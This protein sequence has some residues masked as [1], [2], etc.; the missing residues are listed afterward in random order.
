MGANVN[1]EVHLDAAALW[2]ASLLTLSPPAL[3]PL[4]SASK[5]AR[6]TGMTPSTTTSVPAAD[7]AKAAAAPPMPPRLTCWT[8][9]SK[10]HVEPYVNNVA[11]SRGYA[12]RLQC[13]Q[14]AGKPGSAG[15]PGLAGHMPAGCLQSSPRR[16]PPRQ[17]SMRSMRH[18]D[19]QGG[20]R[21]ARYH[22]R[23]DRELGYDGRAG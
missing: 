18:Q 16:R 7:G 17:E 2:T 20:R 23:E 1:R 15:P 22:H 6:H 4:A 11:A 9:A 5:P 10:Q 19:C 3:Y 8:P 12:T 21:Q 13:G 14:D